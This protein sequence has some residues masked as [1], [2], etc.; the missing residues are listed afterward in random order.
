MCCSTQVIESR[1]W[2]KILHCLWQELAGWWRA[3]GADSF[4]FH[5]L[6]AAEREAAGKFSVCLLCCH[7]DYEFMVWVCV[8]V[9]F[10]CYLCLCQG[11]CVSHWFCTFYLHEWCIC[12]QQLACQLANLGYT[13]QHFL[14]M[15][16]NRDD[17]LIDIFTMNES[18]R[19]CYR[20]RLNPILLSNQMM[21]GKSQLL[22]LIWFEFNLLMGGSGI[23][24]QIYGWTS[25]VKWLVVILNRLSPQLPWWL[26]VF[27]KC[28]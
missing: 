25:S 10:S 23:H 22:D 9:C 2:S 3:W 24:L 27:R 7:Y 4:Y 26:H 12:R 5:V 17:S 19:A 14:L 16:M 20:T 6:H 13:V 28:S 1:F 21:M 11:L 18:I 8:G 15:N